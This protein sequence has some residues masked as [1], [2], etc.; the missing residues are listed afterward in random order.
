MCFAFSTSPTPFVKQ[1]NRAT[2]ETQQQAAEAGGLAPV[3]AYVKRLV[4]RVI[5]EDFGRGDLEF[6]WSEDREFDPLMTISR[7]ATARSG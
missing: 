5:G 3:M 7:C 2:A 4:D 1:Q 6:V